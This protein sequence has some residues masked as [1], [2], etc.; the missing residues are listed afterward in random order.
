MSHYFNHSLYQ[1]EDFEENFEELYE[2]PLATTSQP[3]TELE[4]EVFDYLNDTPNARESRL[5]TLA[6]RISHELD[7]RYSLA[8]EIVFKWEEAT[9]KQK[10]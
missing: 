5:E 10:I 4:Q 7:V 3:L 1:M 6:A 8:W 9:Q 2:A